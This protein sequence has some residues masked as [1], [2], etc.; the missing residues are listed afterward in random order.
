MRASLFYTAVII[1]FMWVLAILD[2]IFFSINDYGI[3]PREIEGLI[4]IL[5]SPFL[6]ADLMQYPQHIIVNSL[7]LLFL[8]PITFLFY[9]KTSWI[10]MAVIVILGGFLVWLIAKNG[11]N[12]IGASGLIYG[13]LAFLFFSGILRRNL[14]A[15]LAAITVFFA[16]SIIRYGVIPQT[17]D[18]AM[19]L[20]GNMIENFLTGVV[21]G[22][23]GVSWE[24][25]LFGAVGGFL[26]AYFLRNEDD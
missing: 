5:T 19:G 3:R 18:S 10:A 15:L 17:V 16:Y 20:L 11:S 24:G 1:A 26:S 7:F 13:L 8:L 4:G 22:R 23:P 21:P 6:H 14:K 9:R 12:H 2:I 25:H